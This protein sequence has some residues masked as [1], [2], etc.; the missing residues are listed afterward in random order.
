MVLVIGSRCKNKNDVELFDPNDNSKFK[1]W[2]VPTCQ[3]G[4]Q[5]SVEPGSAHPKTTTIS[6]IPC[7]HGWF[8][9]HDTNYRCQKCTSCGNRG[10]LVNCSIYGDA[11]CSKSCK[12]KTHYF[13][14]SDGQCYACTECCG[15]DESNIER[16]CL[17]S[18]NL[19]V[20]S[21]IGQQGELHCKV[22]SSQKCDE[23]SKNVTTYT[24]GSSV[25]NGTS[26]V[27]ENCNCTR[28]ENNVSSTYINHNY[29]P[30]DCSW[31]S[32]SSLRT[33]DIILICAL[34]TVAIASAIFLYLYIRE[35]RMRLSRTCYPSSSES[36]PF[37]N[38][39]CSGLAGM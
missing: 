16:Q 11:V 13:N 4:Q 20:G 22:Q 19:R 7:D 10:V 15:K 6:C 36:C 5:P 18:G 1:C 12:S 29:R 26:S 32:S 33:Q 27:L 17:S 37:M 3:E 24:N 31:N 8:S 14:E 23:L 9:N 2:P 25:V 39:C 35:R 34:T 30:I 21:V 38:L 28:P